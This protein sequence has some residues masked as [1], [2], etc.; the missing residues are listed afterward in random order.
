MKTDALRAA[1][2]LAIIV[3][4]QW[5]VLPTGGAAHLFSS[6]RGRAKGA[7]PSSSKS[8]AIVGSEPST[9]ETLPARPTAETMPAP[10]RL[11]ETEGRGL[12]VKVWVN[13]IGDFNFALDTGAGATILSPRVA[14]AAQVE[15]ESG[16]RGIEV[17]GLSGLS[18]AGGR[19]AFTH[20]IAVGTS[21]NFLP[22][23]G[24]VIVAEGLPPDA[25]GILDPTEVYAP[26]GYVIDLPG[27]ELSA[28]DPRRFPVRLAEA[29]RDAAI[30][31]WLTDGST[32]R[33]FVM[34]GEG[35]RALLDTGSGLG[36]AVN[37]S[38]AGALGIAV[39]IGARERDSTR[40]LAGGRISS[41]RV[42][43]ATVHIGALVLRG[44]PTDVLL[45]AQRD[46]PVLLG[47]DALRPFRI[48]FDPLNRLI[49][50][51]SL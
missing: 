8:R 34:L 2:F 11:H 40:D 47:R 19:K 46:A 51:E 36:L 28:F 33:P 4:I 44:V 10:A 1:L 48:T 50:F 16:A 18:V 9:A 23:Q 14:G 45:S 30:V 42:S 49:M 5:A 21:E 20:S 6:Q 41:R 15:V 27:G 29:Q 3:F 39:G 37:E 43:A 32:R 7:R 25:D 13:G 35:R 24:L 31:P 17:G 38:S 12:L 26:L 22:S